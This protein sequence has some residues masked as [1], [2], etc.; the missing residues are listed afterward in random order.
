MDCAEV[1]QHLDLLLAA[2]DVHQSDAVGGADPNEHLPEVGGGGGV[3]ERA[4]ALRAHCLDHRQRGQRVDE[5]RCALGGTHLVGQLHDRGCVGYTVISPHRPAE[6]RDAT[7]DQ[8][9]RFRARRDHGAGTLVTDRQRPTPAATRPRRRWSIAD[10][11]A[12]RSRIGRHHEQPFESQTAAYRRLAA[13]A[14]DQPGRTHLGNSCRWARQQAPHI[15]C[16]RLS[17][18]YAEA[19]HGYETGV[20]LGLVWFALRNSLPHTYRPAEPS[21]S[22]GP[23]VRADRNAKDGAG[24]AVERSE[25]LVAGETP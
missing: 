11:A 17:L 7:A 14:G 4:M 6:Q 19:L 1:A 8:R 25:R 12:S 18:G 22:E 9:G 10:C 23:P 13:R 21:G 5:Q 16:G 3:D 15:R 24:A 2:H 20:G